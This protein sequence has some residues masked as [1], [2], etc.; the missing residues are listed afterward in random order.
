MIFF[1]EKYYCKTGIKSGLIIRSDADPDC[2][3]E[4][5]ACMWSSVQHFVLV[6]QSAKIFPIID[7][8]HDASVLQDWI[9]TFP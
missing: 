8:L 5:K 3:A 7:L 1:L 6:L 4:V 9:R 2:E